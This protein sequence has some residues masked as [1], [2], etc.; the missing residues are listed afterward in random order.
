MPLASF[1][2][3]D[4]DCFCARETA[5][6]APGIG[7]H[8]VVHSRWRLRG[9]LCTRTRI[10]LALCTDRRVHNVGASEV[11]EK[12]RVRNACERGL[13]VHNVTCARGAADAVLGVRVHKRP[14]RA[15]GVHNVGAPG[16]GRAK[17][18]GERSAAPH[19]REATFSPAS[20]CDGRV[21]RGR[22]TDFLLV[23]KCFGGYDVLSLAR[24][25]AGR[26]RGAPYNPRS[27]GTALGR[28]PGPQ[29]REDTHHGMLSRSRS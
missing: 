25:L 22:T 8:R 3:A 6:G 23:F 11:G 4:A 29:R 20:G 14:R 18:P 16:I 15:H 24:G 12:R 2:W 13:W 27:R 10:Y 28:A 19:A 9:P 5:Q 26:A 1:A 17:T 7:R 21:S